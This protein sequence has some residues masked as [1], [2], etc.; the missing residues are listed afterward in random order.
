MLPD[1]RYSI[2]DSQYGFDHAEFDDDSLLAFAL[3]NKEPYYTNRQKVSQGRL[4]LSQQK[5]D[6]YLAQQS[7]GTGIY[8]MFSLLVNFGINR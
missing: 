8:T 4:R 3:S 1:I 2:D 6:T 7:K 5:Q